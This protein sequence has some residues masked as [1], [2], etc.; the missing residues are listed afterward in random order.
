MHLVTIKMISLV[1]GR[2]TSIYVHL[3]D[4]SLV[5]TTM[6]TITLLSVAQ[7]LGHVCL[8]ATKFPVLHYLPEFA[9]TQGH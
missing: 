1:S 9:Q 7:S 8:L 3:K 6:T 5:L 2:F 4:V